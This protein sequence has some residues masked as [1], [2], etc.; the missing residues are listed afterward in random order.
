MYNLHT[1]ITLL[2][3]VVSPVRVVSALPITTQTTAAEVH[4]SAPTVPHKLTINTQT[5]GAVVAHATAAQPNIETEVIEPLRA[6]QAAK[7]QAEA[8]AT[9][10][11]AAEAQAAAVQQAAAQPQIGANTGDNWYKLR[12]C[13]SGNDYAKNTGNG[14]FGAYQYSPSTWNNYGGFARP[15]L[16]PAAVQDAKAQADYARRGWTPW[17]SCSKRLSAM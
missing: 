6:T 7:A 16:A 15:D 10:R 11:A 3:L 17:P 1:L 4:A 9:A 8:E 12:L 5:A 2:L 13:E 14:Y